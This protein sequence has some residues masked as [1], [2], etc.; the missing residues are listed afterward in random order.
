[1]TCI[2]YIIYT[3][4]RIPIMLSTKEHEQK[5][6]ALM[7]GAVRSVALYGLE[8]AST[9]TISACCGI[10]EAYIYRYF[11]SK[12]DLL[13]KTFE[14][15]DKLFLDMILDNFPVL[16]YESIDYEVR[17]RLLFMRCW[18]Y[19][20]GRPSEL[21]F[22]MRYYHSHMYNTYSFVNHTKQ[23][24]ILVD[25]LRSAF[26]AEGGGVEL[27]MRHILDTLLTTALMYVSNPEGIDSDEVAEINF[28]MIFSVVREF[29]DKN[30]LAAAATGKQSGV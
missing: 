8:N 27:I 6:A 17:C 13:A 23:Y 10:N 29:I 2:L 18:K 5:T 22:Y 28:K 7:D 26:P 25:K 9:K 24:S 16:S 12:E 19:V 30:K 11:E 15:E 4:E 20:T 21:K 1:M 14:R 3:K